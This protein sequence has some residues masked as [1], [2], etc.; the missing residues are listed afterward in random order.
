MRT[1]FNVFR[2]AARALPLL[3]LAFAMAS[4]RSP[5]SPVGEVRAVAID[6][7]A[8]PSATNYIGVRYKAFLAEDELSET[9]W[10][11]L[12]A[13][14]GFTKNGEYQPHFIDLM[15]K[16]G[17]AGVYGDG[18]CA[19]GWP[20]IESRKAF[21]IELGL[22][23]YDDLRPGMVLDNDI[24]ARSQDPA[25]M[26]VHFTN[27]DSSDRG[28]PDKIMAELNVDAVGRLEGR[29][30]EVSIE[31][32][33][34][35]RLAV[36]A[37]YFR[38]PDSGCVPAAQDD[39]LYRRWIARVNVPSLGVSVAVDFFI[40][41]EEGDKLRGTELLNFIWENPDRAM[42]ETDRYRV[43]IFEPEARTESG[44]WVPLTRFVFD[45]RS[46]S[47][48]YPRDAQGRITAG[49]RKVNYKGRP[50][51][52][53]SMGFGLGDYVTDADIEQYEPTVAS[54]GVIDLST[55]AVDHRLV[56]PGLAR[57]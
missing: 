25:R 8:E 34:L 19:A 52:E 33:E 24:A 38:D 18:H 10:L 5:E 54:M 16:G 39:I 37:D 31:R 29:E 6:A 51:I 7:R 4:V 12:F 57:Q 26:P 41:A 11:L 48:H 44:A 27:V 9:G 21:T 13:S 3:A 35:T 14:S 36:G 1:E 23:D 22:S 40:N 55:P 47:S 53:A 17:W 56:I 32:A 45:L 46:P 50:A 2:F 43:I 30:V 42:A 20:Q 15:I 49:F 28:A